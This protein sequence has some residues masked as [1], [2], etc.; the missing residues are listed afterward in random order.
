MK[1]I[2]WIM[3][4]VVLAVAGI[5]VW[6]WQTSPEVDNV[7][8]T[9]AKISDIKELAELCTTEIY[10]DVPVQGYVGTRHLVA[11]ATL[12]GTIS[13]EL[14]SMDVD[15]TGDTVRV[16]LPAEKVDV[17]ESTEPNS[18]VVIDSWNDRIFSKQGFTTAEEN[19]LKAMVRDNFVK[20][21]YAK[22]YVKRARAEAVSN[23]ESTL[24]AMTG[25]PVEVTDPT[26]NGAKR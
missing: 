1:A 7:K 14:D 22:G 2:K 4:L 8:M 25:R 3:A 15:K 23:L 11:R 19:K 26:P 12:R 6:K 9:S 16:T 24:G 20:Q 5:A 10:E 17:K 18:Y 13:F 21:I